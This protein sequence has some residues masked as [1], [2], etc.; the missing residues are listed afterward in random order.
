MPFIR[1]LVKAGYFVNHTTSYKSKTPAAKCF[2]E[3]DV[4][5]KRFGLAEISDEITFEAD[6]VM[7]DVEK[8]EN[9]KNSTKDFLTVYPNG[10]VRKRQLEP[11][12]APVAEIIKKCNLTEK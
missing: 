12:S 7:I 3:S 1:E 6:K 10:I 2:P 5:V 8:T 11:V 4:W 9:N